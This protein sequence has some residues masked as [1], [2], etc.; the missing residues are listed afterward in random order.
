MDHKGKSPIRKGWT[1]RI[2]VM[3]A[4]AFSKLFSPMPT[5]PAEY[6]VLAERAERD[7]LGLLMLWND[8]DLVQDVEPS[9]FTSHQ[10]YLIFRGIETAI[11]ANSSFDVVTV[12]EIL[13]KSGKL[14]QAGGLLYL[15]D[16]AIKSPDLATWQIAHVLQ[17]F[18]KM[19]FAM[20]SK[21]GLRCIVRLEDALLH[22][23]NHG[24]S[25]YSSGTQLVNYEAPLIL[26]LL[27]DNSEWVCYSFADEVEAEQF[28]AQ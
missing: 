2:S 13:E 15:R 1:K 27:D 11:E 14:E 21:N 19:R 22:G 7:L 10:H 3:D 5:L 17:G 23:W 16:I 20:T 26:E 24:A 18:A 4:T 28:F 25:W 6:Q 9:W 12:V 8:R